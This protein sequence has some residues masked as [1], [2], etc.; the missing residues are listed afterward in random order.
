MFIYSLRLKKR[1]AFFFLEYL[2]LIV[3]FLFL[4]IINLPTL[5][6]KKVPSQSQIFNLKI[7][8]RG[9]LNYLR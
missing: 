9:R 6:I 7:R 4:D 8:K 1:V 5:A 2:K 3:P